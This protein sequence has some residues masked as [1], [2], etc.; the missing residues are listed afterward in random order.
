MKV[1]VDT[2]VLVAGLLSPFGPP[3]EIVRMIATGH[4][5]VCF[6]ARILTEYEDVLARPKLRFDADSTRVLLEQLK[7][8]GVNVTG[9]PLP[10]GLPDPE[11]EPFLE[12]AV[13]GQVYSLITGNLKHF[14][15]ARRLGVLVLSPGEFLQSFRTHTRPRRKQRQGS[16]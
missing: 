1:V 14:P 8:E 2:N 13:S 7:A 12:I 6:D 4:I 16:S 11:D 3:A 5:Q 10:V 9:V 15:L